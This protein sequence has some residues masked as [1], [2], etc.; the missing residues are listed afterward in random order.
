MDRRRFASLV[1]LGCVGAPFPSVAQRPSRIPQI[2]FL[3]HPTFESRE[4]QALVEAFRQGLREHAYVEGKNIVIQY[5]SAQGRSEDLPRL[6]RELVALEV[7]VIVLGVGRVAR[8]ASEATTTIPIVAAV[9]GDPVEEGFAVSLARPG[10]NVTGLSYLSKEMIPKRLSLLK[11]LLPQASRVTGLWQSR[12]FGGDT[13]KEMLSDS[14]TVAKTI[15]IELH[16]VGMG[17]SAK[18][19]DTFA[20]IVRKR[21]DALFMFPSTALFF[22]RRRV[23]DL[24]TKYRL[25]TMYYD[26]E[27]A[28]VGGLISYG[29][30]T[31]DLWRRSAAYVDKI[32]K[33]AKPRD[34]PIELPTKFELAINLPT[35]KS[36]G[37]TIPQS[38]LLRAD[39]VIE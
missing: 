11:D 18:L 34:L 15:G 16:P 32:L 30:S 10:G 2:G 29:A 26:R 13:T 38:V 22:E 21:P 8:I 33:G 37:I 35:A 5:R 4:V 24:A 7:D 1:A 25:P 36:L 28:R 17:D 6:A 20:A 39:E 9:M 31:H 19:E 14:E 3:A 27:F 12:E 23:V